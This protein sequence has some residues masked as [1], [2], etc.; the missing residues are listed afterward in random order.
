MHNSKEVIENQGQNQ[1]RIIF[2]LKVT[3]FKLAGDMVAW[4]MYKYPG[5]MY[6]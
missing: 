5:Y 6:R 4:Y 2:S 1:L 3:F